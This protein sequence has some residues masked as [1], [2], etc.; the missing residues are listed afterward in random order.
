MR[1]S[2]FNQ[3]ER[4]FGVAIFDEN[5]DLL[6]FAAV[7]YQDLNKVWSIIESDTKHRLYVVPGRRVVNTVG[8]AMTAK[9]WVTGKEEYRW[10]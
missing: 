6:T 5:D 10:D 7:Q 2:S 1:T 9:P 3:F 8:Y 4:D